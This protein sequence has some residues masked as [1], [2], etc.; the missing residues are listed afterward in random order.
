MT[1]AEILDGIVK[2]LFSKKY[3][4]RYY[5]SRAWPCL[6]RLVCSRC[7]LITSHWHEETS[8]GSNG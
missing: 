1:G 6:N 2:C 7:G 4:L 8:E 3:R 5:V